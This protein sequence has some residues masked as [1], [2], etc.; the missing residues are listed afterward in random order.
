MTN[1]PG[2]LFFLER[3]LGGITTHPKSHH[4]KLNNEQPEMTIAMISPLDTMVHVTSSSNHRCQ[5]PELETYT[6]EMC[7]SPEITRPA[8][9]QRKRSIR[10]NRTTYIQDTTHINDMTS[11]EITS[12][13]YSVS[14]EIQTKQNRSDSPRMNMDET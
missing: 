13:W 14:T 11:K 2:T 3:V 5:S 10:F 8:E 7:S 6:F 9:R 12:A 1:V 4:T